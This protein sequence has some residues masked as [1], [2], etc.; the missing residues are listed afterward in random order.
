[1]IN[2]MQ[3]KQEI[4]SSLKQ[5]AIKQGKKFMF[6]IC[7]FLIRDLELTAYLTRSN[8]KLSLTKIYL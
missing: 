5:L 4:I 2:T 7:Y 6:I 8:I 1:M 3:S